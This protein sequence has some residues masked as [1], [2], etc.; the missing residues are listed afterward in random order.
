MPAPWVVFLHVLLQ[1][2]HGVEGRAQTAEQEIIKVKITSAEWILDESLKALDGLIL[3]SCEFCFL[4]CCK[5]A[6]LRCFP[7]A[8]M[9]CSHRCI[10]AVSLF[11]CH[12]LFLSLGSGPIHL[13][14]P[15][16]AAAFTKRLSGSVRTLESNKVFWLQ[17]H[18]RA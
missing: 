13:F 18:S 8:I 3:F 10:P 17:N 5:C 14:T 9:C 12:F 11:F 15:H 7:G 16:S 2:G 6:R 1:K 4:L